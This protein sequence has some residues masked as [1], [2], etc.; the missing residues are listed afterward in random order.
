MQE[1]LIYKALSSINMN[2]GAVTKS[3]KNEK[4][5][6]NFRGIDDVMNELHALFSE[7]EVIIAPEV[8]DYN[9]TEKVSS[10]GSVLF[11]TRATI[12]FHFIAKDGSELCVTNVGEAMDGGDKS[13]NKAMSVALKYALMQMFLIPTEEKKDPDFETH[14]IVTDRVARK[15]ELLKE[16]G[17]CN[18]YEEIIGMF[19]QYP[20][21]NKDTDVIEACSRRRKECE[22][23]K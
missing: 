15:N 18:S 14:E 21:L 13:M 4:Q 12:R 5:K 8:I 1:K 10:T 6:F 11:Y 23:A 20:E 17:L 16:I 9:V 3:R 19:K 22:N 7:N 2:V